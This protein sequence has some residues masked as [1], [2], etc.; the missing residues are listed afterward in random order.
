METTPLNNSKKSIK[1]GT[2][3][4]KMVHARTSELASIAGR[5]PL[6]VSQTDYEQAKHELTGESDVDRQEAI[7]ESIPEPVPTGR[8]QR[9]SS[10][11]KE[12]D[13]DQSEN[14]QLSEEVAKEAE[15]DQAFHAAR[16]DREKR[17]A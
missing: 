14:E 9:E 2:V 15:R 16:A 7:L 1:M 3:T 11:E 8:Q 17:S 13:K 6:D 12:D 4:R 5:A 10:K